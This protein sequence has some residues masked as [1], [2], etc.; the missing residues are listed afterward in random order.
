MKETLKRILKS[1]QLYHPLQT[2]YRSTLRS[3]HNQLL[4][5]TYAKY[6]GPGFECNFCGASYTTFVPEYPTPDIKKA[7]EENHVIAGF[8]PNVY[9]PNCLSKN[10]ERL[11]KCVLQQYASI[12]EKK[13]LQFSP[14][15]HLHRFLKETAFVTTADITPGFYRHIDPNIQQAD[16]TRLPYPD[17]SYDILIANHIL[18]HIPEDTTAMRELFRVLN[19]K[20][21]AILQVPYSE[22]I[23][24]TI[25]E[26]NIDDPVRQAALFGQKDHVRIYAKE[27]YIKRLQQAGFNVRILSPETLAPFRIHAI[28]E[29]ESVFLCDKNI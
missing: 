5:L 7:I 20:G 2:A 16:A 18:E 14:E 29:N 3:A 4:R 23:I 21:L 22:K 25:E 15:P 10:R 13:I 26:P 11:I 12:K 1:L 17:E 28:Q 27:D 8:G 24:K 9:C 6:K 19:K